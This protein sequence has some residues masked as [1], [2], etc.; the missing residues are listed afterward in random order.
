[1]ATNFNVRTQ[2]A[3]Y[4]AGYGDAMHDLIEARI[5]DYGSVNRMIEWLENNARPEDAKR[6]GAFYA[7]QAASA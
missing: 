6:L 5:S 7:A 4:T 2:R 1:M 3:A